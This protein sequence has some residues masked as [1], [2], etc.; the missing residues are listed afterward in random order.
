[1][2]LIIHGRVKPLKPPLDTPLTPGDRIGKLNIPG[3][4]LFD[5]Y[6]DYNKHGVA[7]FVNQDLDPKNIKRLEGNKRTVRRL[8]YCTLAAPCSLYK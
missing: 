1:M 5:K 3:I 7:T 6:I 2:L 4:Q 8:D